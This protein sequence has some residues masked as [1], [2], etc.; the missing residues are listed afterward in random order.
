MKICTNS[1]G[2]IT[3]MAAY[4][5]VAAGITGKTGGLIVSVASIHCP[6][7]NIFKLLFL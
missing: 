7:V 6:S 3:N 4:K 1:I 2:H 5:S